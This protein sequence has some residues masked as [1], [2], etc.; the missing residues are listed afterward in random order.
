MNTDMDIM[1]TFMLIDVH[2]D[3][4]IDND[5]IMDIDADVAAIWMGM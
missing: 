3:M 5:M 2:Q 1:Q 4:D